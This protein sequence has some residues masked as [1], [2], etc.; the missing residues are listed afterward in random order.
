MTDTT[1]REFD[2][3]SWGPGPWIDEPD[4]VEFEHDGFP[5]IILRVESGSLCGY[6]AVPPGHPWHGVDYSR[7][8][9][10]REDVPE[11]D[12]HGGVTYA[13]K[14]IGQV[15]H[16][17]KPGEPDD[18]WWLG[19]DHAHLYDISPAYAASPVFGGPA[20]IDPMASYKTIQYVRRQCESLAEQAKGLL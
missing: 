14:C 11:P 18:V 13:R 16:M 4:R 1:G 9:K 15:C 19:F 8:E 2:K 6:V 17:P 7:W 10:G 20:W 5:C 12:C 3:A